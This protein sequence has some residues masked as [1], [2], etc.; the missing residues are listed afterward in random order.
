[1][2]NGHKDYPPAAFIQ[3]LLGDKHIV[4]QEGIGG[5]LLEDMPRRLRT[6]LT[7]RAAK[8]RGAVN[9][10]IFWGGTNDIR[11]GRSA[12]DV[13]EHFGQ[14]IETCRVNNSKLIVLTLPEMECEKAGS[15]SIGLNRKFFNE[16]L[17][18]N[19]DEGRYRIVDVASAIPYFSLSGEEE[20]KQWYCDG[21]HFTK[22]G[23]EKVA[24][25]VIDVI[26]RRM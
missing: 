17:K 9:C 10:V 4:V 5:D 1:M 7:E 18:T 15:G 23:Y 24:R 6:S 26:R 25:L 8:H 21:L 20:K 19:A 11:C 16:L 22:N 13:F 3:R 2:T 12:E 14:V